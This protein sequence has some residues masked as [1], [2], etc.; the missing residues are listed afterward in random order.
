MLPPTPFCRLIVLGATALCLSTAA[1]AADDGDIEVRVDRRGDLVVV[2]GGLSVAASPEEAWAVLTDFDHMA[3][4]IS[5]LQVSHVVSVTGQTIHVEQKGKSSH[6]PFSI[7]F[8]SVKAYE[9]KPFD[10]IRTHLI[11]G[12][13]KKFEGRMDLVAQ[14]ATTRLVYHGESIPVMWVPPLIGPAMVRSEIREQ[15][16][17]LRDEIL[18]RKKIES[19]TRSPS[20]PTQ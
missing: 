16:G 7:D 5:N 19:G 8:E 11:S 18:R 3:S 14:G 10:S 1:A 15:F 13:F 4:F 17:E 2:D 9:L 12:T 6:G 20:P